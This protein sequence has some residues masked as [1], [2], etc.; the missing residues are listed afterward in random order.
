M[1]T[2]HIPST[3]FEGAHSTHTF[4]DA[5]VTSEDLRAIY[6]AAKFGP[7][8]MN[9]TP[10]RIAAVW[11]GE[12]R[13]TLVSAMSTANQPKTAAAPLV[14]VLAYDADFHE[15]LDLLVPHNPRARES[16]L[17]DAS[18]VRWAEKQAWLQAGYLITAIR[19]AGFAAGPMSGFD[20]AQVDASLLADTTWHSFMVVLVGEA[21]PDG[22]H[23]RA[24][25]VDYSTAV[26][27][28]R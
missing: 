11:P 24:P 26:K 14:L 10:L 9:T 16:F 17:D 5:P 7:T 19:A 2:A 8:A 22:W 20:H 18:R 15:Y 21:A 4:T 25:R 27:E 13:E 1:M 23:P 28:L 6:D 12:S 3:L